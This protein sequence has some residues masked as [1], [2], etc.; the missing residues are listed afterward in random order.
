V[1]PNLDLLN[2]SRSERAGPRAVQRFAHHRTSLRHN[3]TSTPAPIRCEILKPDR[4]TILHTGSN[5][6]GSCKH[7]D[8]SLAINYRLHR[9][10]GLL[11]AH[12]SH[13]KP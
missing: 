13:N 2:T 3:R 6:C 11:R 9:A 10:T 5:S 12:A 7:Q 1:A 4:P 8:S